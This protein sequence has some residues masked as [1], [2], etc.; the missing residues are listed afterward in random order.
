MGCSHYL[1]FKYILLSEPLPEFL[2]GD[3]YQL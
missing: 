3:R 2:I 1:N